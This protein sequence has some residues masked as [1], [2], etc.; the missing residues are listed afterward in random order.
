VSKLYIELEHVGRLDR[1]YHILDIDLVGLWRRAWL[2]S[3][4]ANLLF[5]TAVT[6]QAL[7]E[8]P[9]NR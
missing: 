5:P 3:S 1:E 8:K 9:R 7:L 4:F 2:Q 6:S